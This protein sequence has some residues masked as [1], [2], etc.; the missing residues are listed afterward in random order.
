MGQWKPSVL[1]FSQRLMYLLYLSAGLGSTLHPVSFNWVS[2]SVTP[3]GAQ[4]SGQR[5]TAGVYELQSQV[6]RDAP[7]EVSS[8][9][10]SN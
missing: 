3:A 7:Q 5:E 6:V 2:S 9:S 8:S 4:S 10:N 1:L